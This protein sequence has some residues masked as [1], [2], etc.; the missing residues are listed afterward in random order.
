MAWIL[1][2]VAGLFEVVWSFAMKQSQGFTRLG[3]PV[4]TTAPRIV[5]SALRRAP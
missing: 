2:T 1:L 5:A 4:I 3:P